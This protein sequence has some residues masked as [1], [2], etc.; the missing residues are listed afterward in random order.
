MECER[1]G[2]TLIYPCP[3]CSLL[4][5]TGIKELNC[6][7]FRHG[8][9]IKRNQQ[10]PPHE[11]KEQCDRWLQHSDIVGCCKPYE[12]VKKDATF[13]VQVCDYK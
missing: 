4:I 10:I 12:I 8:F 13:Y 1:D 6:H 7:I 5:T 3:H 9:L 11:S 2:D